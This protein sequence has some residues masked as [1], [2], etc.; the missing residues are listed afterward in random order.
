[1]DDRYRIASNPPPG[2]GQTDPRLAADRHVVPGRKQNG[3][4]VSGLLWS[5]LAVLVGLNA[6]VPIAWPG[7]VLLSL[8]CGIPAVLCIVLLVLRYLARR[9]S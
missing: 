3:D 4:W 1:M 7:A 2:V 5:V 6:V 9:R 8:A